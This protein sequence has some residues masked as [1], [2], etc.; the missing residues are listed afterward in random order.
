MRGGAAR[1]CINRVVGIAGF[2]REDFERVPAEHFFGARQTRLA[3]PVID[4]RFVVAG[5]SGRPRVDL[6]A[7]AGNLNTM[8]GH[9]PN[10]KIC[11]VVKAN[12][13]GHGIDRIWS[14]LSAT[15]GFALLNLEEAILELSNA[16]NREPDSPDGFRHL[17]TA[18]SRKGQIGLAELNSARAFFTA[19]DYSNAANH[20]AR[21]KE[22]LPANSPGWYKADEI[23]NYRPPKAG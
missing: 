8:R 20:A 23:L 4:L 10:V 17:A 11:G 18:Y 12:A 14:A 5:T 7:I 15:D 1:Y 22:K 21:A 9:C 3:P 2:E 6:D 16:V 13:Y 19:G